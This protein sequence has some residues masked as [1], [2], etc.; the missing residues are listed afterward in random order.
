V[1]LD[2]MVSAAHGAARPGFPL[3]MGVALRN[4]TGVLA[5][6]GTVTFT[7]DPVL[8]FVSATGS[9]TVN[10]NILTWSIPNIGAL[11]ERTFSVNFEVPADVG[12]IGTVL[13]STVTASVSNPEANLANNSY[14]YER[15]VTGSYDPNDKTALT[16]SR[17][18]SEVYNIN[19]DEWIDY[20]IRF[21]NTGTDTAFFVVITDTLPSALDPATFLSMA[22]SHTHSVSL[23]GQGILR[24][25]FPAILLPDS[26]VN[27]PLSHGFVSF[28]IRPKQPVLPGTVIENV[29]N[30]YFDYNEPVITEPSVLVAEFSTAVVEQGGSGI[31]LSPVPASDLL[32]ITSLQDIASVLI[33]TVD[34]R[35]VFAQGVTSAAPSINV[36]RLNPGAYLLIATFNDGTSARQCFIKQ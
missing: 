6:N 29:A 18:S 10:G 13:S 25:N 1:G 2:V 3:T 31:S 27:E 19:T 24:W 9:P 5:G 16:S 36:S 32:H 15:T 14:T 23:S 26:N 7:F 33:T 8:T 22:A 34:G 21:Q 35:V 28:R 11:Q 17:E 4:L 12:L 30:I 20:T